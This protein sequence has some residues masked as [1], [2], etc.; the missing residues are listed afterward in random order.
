M[1]NSTLKTGKLEEIVIVISEEEYQADLQRGLTEDETLSPGIHRF[2]RGG[3]LARHLISVQPNTPSKVKLVLEL[4][5]DI[6]AYFQQQA[7]L[8]DAPPY[9]TQI[10]NALRRMIEVETLQYNVST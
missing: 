1:N 8:P 10:N 4:D 7:T 3:F 2:K 5:A 6:L 9:Q